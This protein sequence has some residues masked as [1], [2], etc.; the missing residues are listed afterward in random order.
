[1]KNNHLNNFFIFFCFE[2]EN[3]MILTQ[4]PI[5]I[6]GIL[7]QDTKLIQRIKLH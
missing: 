3:K 1:M 5:M 6:N 4:K 7:K 2:K